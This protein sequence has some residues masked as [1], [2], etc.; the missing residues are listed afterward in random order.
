MTDID[1]TL[2]DELKMLLENIQE[3]ERG[4]T[5]A[6]IHTT[7]R[8]IKILFH[9]KS[10]DCKEFASELVGEIEFLEYPN[11]KSQSITAYAQQIWVDFNWFFSTCDDEKIL[12]KIIS[13]EQEII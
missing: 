5:I 4:F 13:S 1:Q 12:Q 6:S 3:N 10:L 11:D 2:C 8:E 9:R 7:K